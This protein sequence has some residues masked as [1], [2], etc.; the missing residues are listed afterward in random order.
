MLSGRAVSGF[1]LSIGTGLAFESIFNPTQPVYDQARKSP[2]KVNLKN[3]THLWVNVGTL[4][5]N[6]V[7]ACKSS[8]VPGISDSE[9]KDALA[10]EMETIESLCKNEGNGLITPVFYFCTYE[11]IY[12]NPGHKSIVL[13]S[14]NTEK[15]KVYI[16][17]LM[18]AIKMLD[19]EHLVKILDS[20]LKPS[21][22]QKALILTNVAWD[23]VSSKHFNRLDLI[24]SHTGVLKNKTAWNTKYHKYKDLSNLPFNSKLLKIF[25]D[26]EIFTPMLTSL[27]DLV[28]GVAVKGKWT[29]LTTKDKMMLDL[30]MYCNDKFVVHVIKS[31]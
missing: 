13:R 30:D 1:A 12:R 15:A 5:R 8:D 27:R 17:K 2:P 14:A 22:N 4:Y 31:L 19:K 7:G 9:F 10:L 20:D 3:Y 18:S 29:V 6:M 24:E 11:S 23:L 16:A 25:G 26:S 21:F 28:L